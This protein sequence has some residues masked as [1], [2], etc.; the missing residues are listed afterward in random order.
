MSTHRP[1]A[2]TRPRSTDTGFTL[3]EILVAIVLVGILSAVAVVGVGRMI[4]QGSSAACSASR[5]AAQTAANV[6][7]ATNASYPSTLDDLTGAGAMTLPSSVAVDASRRVA[8]GEG[9]RLTMTPGA[10]AGPPTFACGTTT[11]GSVALLPV[12][13]A[14][15]WFDATDPA[16]VNLSGG[17]TWSD[18]SGNGRAATAISSSWAMP[19][20]LQLGGGYGSGERSAAA[21]SELLV[22]NRDLTEVERAATEAYLAA[23]W[24]ISGPAGASAMAPSPDV[25][26]DAS[27]APTVTQSGGAVTSWQDKSGRS[28][29]FTASGSGTTYSATGLNGRPAVMTNGSGV[30]TTASLGSATAQTFF[31]VAR[32]TGGINQRVLSGINNNWLLGWWNGRQDQAYFN[33]WLSSPSTAATTTAALYSTIVGTSSRRGIWRNGAALVA[34][35]GWTTGAQQI[36]GL[37]TL[38]TTGELLSVPSLGTTAGGTTAFVVA[39]MTGTRNA[40]VLSGLN[41][42]WLVGW[43]GGQQDQA[44]FSGWLSQ[45]SRAAST[46]AVQ[47]SV[48]TGDGQGSLWRNGRLIASASGSFSNPAGLVIGGAYFGGETSAVSVGEVIIY[49]RILDATERR[50]IESYLQTKWGISPGA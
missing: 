20:G 48:T 44:Y 42:N 29:N 37:A 16:T 8:T 4:G 47:Y 17:A 32:L 12:T 31:V 26:L 3:V 30:L 24:S 50:S 5:D 39:K 6:H 21:I 14:A 11:P 35:G 9:W 34:A 22:Y 27:D 7:F 1:S 46:S 43:W 38:T 2:G 40:R 45:P 41:N 10:S 15:V 28:V 33:Q 36:N 49:N 18:K 13:G 25:W 23:K 19:N